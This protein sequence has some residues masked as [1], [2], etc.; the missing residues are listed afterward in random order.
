MGTKNKIKEMRE[1][2]GLKQSELAKELEI[3]QGTLSN[4]ERG[5]HDPDNQ[6]LAK[7][8][9]MFH[10]STDYLLCM[11]PQAEEADHLHLPPGFKVMARKLGDMPSEDQMAV[12]RIL[13]TTIDAFL[14]L[15]EE[16]RL[17]E[18]LAAKIRHD[19]QEEPKPEDE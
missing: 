6:T 11:E 12:L 4:W 14:L 19:P 10:V 9:Q 1:R 8:A 15:R 16:E 7:L 17:R 13:D 2:A 3:S 18:K 5:I